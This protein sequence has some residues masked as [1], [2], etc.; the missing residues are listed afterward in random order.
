[1]VAAGDDV[2]HGI[3]REL[4][5]T[6][7][8]V[9]STVISRDGVPLASDLP[10]RVDLDV[11]ALRTAFMQG[12]GELVMESVENE[13]ARTVIIVADQHYIMT[14]AIDDHSILV[15]VMARTV[16]VGGMIPDVLATAAHLRNAME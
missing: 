9:A 4:R 6:N 8:V 5:E 15:V 16:E 7:G 11:L 3:L 1:M 2:I 13:E 14:T 10:A 12:I